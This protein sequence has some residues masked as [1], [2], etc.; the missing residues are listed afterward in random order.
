MGTRR[1]FTAEFKAQVVREAE[2]A[3]CDA[4]VIRKYGL[5]KNAVYEWRSHLKASG[6]LEAVQDSY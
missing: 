1:I 6:I 4:A 3:G 5:T 2:E